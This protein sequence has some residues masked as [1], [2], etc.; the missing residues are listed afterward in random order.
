MGNSVV[1][2]CDVWKHYYYYNASLIHYW[3]SHIQ[4]CHSR[5][6][7]WGNQPTKT[8]GVTESIE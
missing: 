8:V 4:G 1:I 2:D 3:I 5:R 6:R 7:F